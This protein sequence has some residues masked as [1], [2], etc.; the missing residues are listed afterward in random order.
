MPNRPVRSFNKNSCSYCEVCS[1]L[2]GMRKNALWVNCTSL[3]T[4]QSR[5]TIALAAIVAVVGALP[6]AQAVATLRLYDGTTTVTVADNSASDLNGDAGIVTWADPI[7]GWTINVTTGMSKPAFGSATLPILDLNSVNVSGVLPATLQIM[8][9]D[10]SFVGGNGE[11]A[12]AVGGTMDAGPGSTATFSAFVDSGNTLFGTST[13]VASAFSF[14]PGAFSGSTT[15]S[16]GALPGPYSVTVAALLDFKS[17]AAQANGGIASFDFA[18]TGEERQVPDSGA[19]FGLLLLALIP[20]A[21]FV[22][23]RKGA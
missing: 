15:D 8:F 5:F 12:L 10:D 21:T 16:L 19:S 18:F 13:P 17:S 7:G 9:S 11:F 1:L 4:M 2:R 3:N 14:G 20:L 6:S 23:R 22:P